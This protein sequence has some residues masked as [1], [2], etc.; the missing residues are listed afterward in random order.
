MATRDS[1]RHDNRDDES[2]RLD[3][4]QKMATSPRNCLACQAWHKARE[5]GREWD[6][7]IPHV[8][9]R[10]FMERHLHITNKQGQKQLLGF[11]D[12]QDDVWEVIYVLTRDGKL[13][14]I[15]VLKSRQVG[16]STG[17]S[18]L[19][20]A[21]TTTRPNTNSM[22]I[23][24][25]KKATANLFQKQQ[26]F[27]DHLEPD[28]KFPLERGNTEELYCKLL[29]WKITL[30]TAGTLAA[31]RS[32][33]LTNILFTEIGYYDDFIGIKSA[34]EASVPTTTDTMI[35]GE[36]T[37][38]GMGSDFHT[39]WVMAEA[40]EIDYYPLFLKWFKDR[41][42]RYPFNND[43]ER[44][45]HL[46]WLFG[47]CPEL[48]DRQ[49]AFGLTAEQIAFY[50]LM[51]KQYNW[52]TQ[53]IQQEFP[54]TPQEA[55]LASGRTVVPTRVI[56]KHVEKAKPG[57]LYDPYMTLTRKSALD[58][59][60][61]APWLVRQQNNYLE[62]WQRPVPGRHYL[63]AVDT[64]QGTEKGDYSCAL[65]F[66][67]ATQRLVAE[68]HGK[69]EPKLLGKELAPQLGRV[70]NGAILVIE[71]DG[72][73]LTTLSYAKDVYHHMYQQ[74]KED[75]FATQVTHKIGW[76]TSVS[77]RT[78]IVANMRHVLGE[79]QAEEGFCPDKCLLD[80]LLVFVEKDSKPQAQKG[81][82]DDRVMTY[83]IGQWTCLEE[84]KIRPEI[85]RVLNKVEDGS[86]T[87]S[88]VKPKDVLRKVADP[89]WYGQAMV[90]GALD[91]PMNPEEDDNAW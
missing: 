86:A 59:W 7:G 22:I 39:L 60:D 1:R 20:Y 54:C 73:G 57:K 38:N 11:N 67:I 77:T 47:K 30:A 48:K 23:G 68:L 33:T 52:D 19:L 6:G 75:G 53:Y 40:G 63:I 89:R 66:D 85:L 72:L 44:D 42:C 31:T 43:R 18:G 71:T 17:F 3:Y 45:E 28:I 32:N 35:I 21:R 79:R 69:M 16:I 2:K 36:S 81:F 58:Q 15:L 80:E 14:R 27:H 74:R 12:S 5:D 78:N 87:V 46:D 76:E 62:M 83:A 70:Y 10:G 82:H 55:W 51:L 9:A 50:G 64:A 91:G 4:L 84:I 29:N 13:I 61:E 26:Y 56:L 37:A 8:C 49:Q 41:T 24:H 34:T 65:V 88:T 90:G 25:H